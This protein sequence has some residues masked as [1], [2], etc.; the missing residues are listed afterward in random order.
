MADSAILPEDDRP[1]QNAPLR[2]GLRIGPAI[3]QGPDAGP[4]RG[5]GCGLNSSDGPGG[6]VHDDGLAGAQAGG[7]VRNADDGGNAVFTG[8]HGAV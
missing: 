3:G 6:S 2:R 4:G 1:F 8:H 7:G 5:V